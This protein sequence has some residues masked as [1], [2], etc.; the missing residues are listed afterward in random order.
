MPKV[1][2]EIGNISRVKVGLHGFTLFMVYIDLI[3]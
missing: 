1:N 2:Q 3:Y